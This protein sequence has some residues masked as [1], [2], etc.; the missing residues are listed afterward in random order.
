MRHTDASI[1]QNSVRSIERLAMILASGYLVVWQ[2]WYPLVNAKISLMT[3]NNLERPM[4]TPILVSQPELL[5]RL[6]VSAVFLK[7]V[8]KFIPVSPT[9]IKY[10]NIAI[11]NVSIFIRLLSILHTSSRSLW[12]LYRCHMQVYLSGNNVP[13]VKPPPNHTS[14]PSMVATFLAPIIWSC[15]HVVDRRC[16]TLL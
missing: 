10:C 16:S 1:L 7:L 2:L 6:I 5:I 9:L 4:I 13:V 11:I 15:D 14:L 8:N 12:M 3:P